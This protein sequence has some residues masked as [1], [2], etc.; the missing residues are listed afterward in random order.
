MD[1]NVSKDNIYDTTNNGIEWTQEGLHISREENMIMSY[2]HIY[3]MYK[4]HILYRVIKTWKSKHFG[5]KCT[6]TP[7]A[8]DAIHTPSSMYLCLTVHSIKYLHSQLN[9]LYSFYEHKQNDHTRPPCAWTKL[10]L[11][12][13]VSNTEQ[14]CIC[15]IPSTLNGPLALDNGS[16][17]PTLELLFLPL[18][19]LPSSKNRMISCG[20]T[21]IPHVFRYCCPRNTDPWSLKLP[22]AN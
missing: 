13:L 22:Q 21:S 1:T 2:I 20:K 8:W 12:T 18:N 17:L 6:P 14:P 19:A 3:I 11:D 5:S 4:F 15:C 9:C 16:N 10:Q 7:V